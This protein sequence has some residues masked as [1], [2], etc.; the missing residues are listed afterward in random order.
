[1]I[2]IITRKYLYIVLLIGVCIGSQRL[3][4]VPTDLLSPGRSD[5]RSNDFRNEEELLNFIQ[6]TME[7]N[8]IPG[9]SISIAKGGSIVWHEHFGYANINENIL[10]GVKEILSFFKKLTWSL[11]LFL[12]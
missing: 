12:N 4:R 8:F 1:M 10:V 7:A 3:N 11:Y 5:T 2:S 9:L 6:S